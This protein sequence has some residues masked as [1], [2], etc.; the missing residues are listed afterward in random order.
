MPPHTL[1]TRT[2]SS[3]RAPSKRVLYRQDAI[4]LTNTFPMRHARTSSG[5]PAEGDTFT[6]FRSP[7]GS[8]STCP[9]DLSFC[10]WTVGDELPDYADH[11]TGFPLHDDPHTAREDTPTYLP[12][13]PR[14]FPDHPAFG[15]RS[16]VPVPVPPAFPMASLH[17]PPASDFIPAAPPPLLLSNDTAL[18]PAVDDTS[19]D[20]PDDTDFQSSEFTEDEIAY[21]TRDRDKDISRGM[22][23]H[24]RWSHSP[25]TIGTKR[26][27]PNNLSS[28][29]PSPIPVVVPAPLP[30][31][32]HAQTVGSVGSPS[33]G[34]RVPRLR[35]KP[36]TVHDPVPT[37]RSR[38]PVSQRWFYES[39]PS[40]SLSPATTIPID[41]PSLVSAVRVND[42]DSTVGSSCLLANATPGPD[43]DS[44]LRREVASFVQTLSLPLQPWMLDGDSRSDAEADADWRRATARLLGPPV[45]ATPLRPDDVTPSRPVSV[46]PLM[47]RALLDATSSSPFV[48]TDLSQAY[49]SPVRSTA[50]FPLT[51][52]PHLNSKVIRRI[53]AAR[54][55]IFK[56][57][58]YL[59]RNDRDADASPER[60]R[61]N[62]GRQLE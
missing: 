49:I 54:E 3:P 38:V 32:P 28:P 8:S 43:M 5:L 42:S 53:L 46:T 52:A 60:L 23:H 15:P 51:S 47:L 34:P 25:T 29:L 31:V 21:T 18:D 35:R 55:S 50:P 22:G 56:Y 12:D 2:L 9:A 24:L 17:L 16:T 6:P 36:P 4:F 61:W 19:M 39:A 20:P 10:G 33:L 58:I 13:W 59:P 62:S 37:P 11:S 30:A 1:S 45:D 27:H 57:G 14:R 48:P 41:V 26:P 44:D 40:T 7:L